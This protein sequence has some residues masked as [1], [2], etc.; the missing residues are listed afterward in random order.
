MG[1]WITLH[2]FNDEAF[3][4]RVVP[5]LCG[6][7]GDLESDYLDFLKSYLI[8]GIQRF[9]NEQVS[10][11]LE[12]SIERVIEIS[13]EFDGSFKRHNEFHKIENYDEKN[14]FLSKYDGYDEYKRFF[15][16]YIFKTCADFFPHIPLGKRGIFSKLE[17]KPKTLSH[18]FMCEFDNYNDFFCS[19]MM[20]IMNWVTKEDVELLYYDKENLKSEYEEF[21]NTFLSF[22]DTAFENKLGLIVGVDMKEDILKLFPS[23]KL[24]ENS[25]WSNINTSGLL[26]K[27]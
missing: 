19:D 17:L 4:K 26:F 2:L 27:I 22:I 16:Y 20:G 21:L 8:G 13:N 15:E 12:Q 24:V 11:L 18:S 23:N 1:Y 7:L 25:Y 5:T 14:L 10:K 6:H 3:Y 9:S